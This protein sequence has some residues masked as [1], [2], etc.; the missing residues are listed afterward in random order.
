MVRFHPGPCAVSSTVLVSHS[1]L[2]SSRF[3]TYLSMTPPP[4]ATL[5]HRAVISTPRA[6]VRGLSGEAMRGGG[7]HLAA[8]WGRLVG[9]CCRARQ[10]GCGADGA[11]VAIRVHFPSTIGSLPV[12][13]CRHHQRQGAV[14]RVK[15]ELCLN[16]F[17]FIFALAK[18]LPAVSHHKGE[19]LLGR[20]VATP[21][22]S[23]KSELNERFSGGMSGLIVPVMSQL[24]HVLSLLAGTAPPHANN[25][26]GFPSLLSRGP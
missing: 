23:H 26:S 9:P 2:L 14:C 1:L 7:Q 10:K 6:A 4:P 8:G 22:P 17:R 16:C 19:E 13:L 12:S 18:L 24:L 5:L 21:L 20:S 3:T 25:N 11:R 15:F